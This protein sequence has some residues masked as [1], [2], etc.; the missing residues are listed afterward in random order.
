M[1][2]IKKTLLSIINL[3]NPV[4][5]GGGGITCLLLSFIG[6]EQKTR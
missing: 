6:K 5:T 3:I 2:T 4:Q 1:I